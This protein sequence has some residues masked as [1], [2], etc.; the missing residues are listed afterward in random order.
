MNGAIVTHGRPIF[1]FRKNIQENPKKMGF[2]PLPDSGISV[3]IVGLMDRMWGGRPSE[4][5]PVNIRN[6]RMDADES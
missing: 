4:S 6:S 1:F 5:V 2:A 3:S